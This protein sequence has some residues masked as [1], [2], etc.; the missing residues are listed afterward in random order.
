MSNI[1]RKMSTIS[2]ITTANNN[3]PDQAD[4]TNNDKEQRTYSINL[5][6]KEHKKKGAN[7]LSR[8]PNVR[9]KGRMGTIWK[10]PGPAGTTNAFIFNPVGIE[11][12]MMWGNTK[13][14]HS[15]GSGIT[16]PAV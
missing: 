15:I 4:Q 1:T 5:I 8:K 9:Y 14:I 10:P 3:P 6:H 2:T 11:P 12:N 13:G 7:T 16:G